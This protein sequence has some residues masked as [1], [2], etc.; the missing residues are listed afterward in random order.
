MPPILVYVDTPLSSPRLSVLRCTGDEDSSTQPRRRGP[1]ARAKRS[2]NDV[3]VDLSQL[4]FADPSLMVDL[5]ML[6]RRLRMRGRGL[7]LHGAQPQVR[8]VIELVGL[9][10]LPGVQMDDWA[11]PQAG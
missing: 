7:F 2:T 11:A 6:A 8:R 1:L 10:H 3:M 4:G 5:A 9:N